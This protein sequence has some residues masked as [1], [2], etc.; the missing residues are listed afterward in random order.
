[1]ESNK[2]IVFDKDAD[3]IDIYAD[4]NETVNKFFKLVFSHL[5]QDTFTNLPALSDYL[6]G[7]ILKICS[8]SS[9][10]TSS[11]TGTSSN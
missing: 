11:K 7:D 6:L 4:R 8:A 10:F 3:P 5:R 2:F 9:S 1:M